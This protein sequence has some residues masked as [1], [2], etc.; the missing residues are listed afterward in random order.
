[1]TKPSVDERIPRDEELEEEKAAKRFWF[2]NRNRIVRDRNR[3]VRP[4]AVNPASIP[5]VGEAVT[6]FEGN[7]V[8]EVRLKRFQIVPHR[9]KVT[10]ES[11][12]EYTLPMGVNEV[13]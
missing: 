5:T 6:K 2:F 11:Y 9:G 3:I 7:Q 13:L 1:M 10:C 4:I 12:V 8:G